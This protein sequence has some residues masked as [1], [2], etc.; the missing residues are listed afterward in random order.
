M[1]S[2]CTLCGLIRQDDLEKAVDGDLGT[3]WLAT[4][5]LIGAG[6]RHHSLTFG[7]G[8]FFTLDR[9]RMISGIEDASG[10]ARNFR[11]QAAS[12]QGPVS[13]ETNHRLG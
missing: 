3:A 8:G 5:F 12:G 1:W 13:V 9:V 10:I 2:S 4:G 11:I 6:T 7:L